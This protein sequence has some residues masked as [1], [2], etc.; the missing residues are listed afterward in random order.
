MVS[1]FV[2]LL[3]CAVM[4]ARSS[5][6]P[7]SLPPRFILPVLPLAIMYAAH[8]LG[9]LFD[10]NT[11]VIGH[12]AT[13]TARERERERMGGSRSVE[14]SSTT[15]NTLLPPRE[16][17][18]NALRPRRSAAAASHAPHLLYASTSSLNVSSSNSVAP[19]LSSSFSSSTGSNGASFTEAQAVVARGRR[20]LTAIF[21]PQ[22]IVFAYFGLWHQRAPLA[23]MEHLTVDLNAQWQRAYYAPVSQSHYPLLHARP[24]PDCPVPV[25]QVTVRRVSLLTCLCLCLCLCLCVCVCV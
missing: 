2:F 19:T 1:H 23:V 17:D 24:Q 15:E 12:I 3:D 5:L 20:W 10:F 25:V 13:A 9:H 7:L 16:A 14:S 8:A 21:L 4:P 11:V 18:D 22:L 6:H